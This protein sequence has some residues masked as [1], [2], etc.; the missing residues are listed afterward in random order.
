MVKELICIKCPKGCRLKV[1]TETLEVIGNSCINGVNYGKTEVTNPV[2]T[3][4]TT[5]RLNNGSI[6]VVSVKSDKP[7]PKE[8][9]FKCMEV[10]NKTS[11]DAPV[12]I[13]DI[14]V[15]NILNTGCNI[16]VTR[17]VEKVDIH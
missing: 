17:N 12:K 2:R 3:I 10:I 6:N 14:A 7:V 16:V 15:H 5:I 9:M 13:G 8:L 1:D 4:T 11:I